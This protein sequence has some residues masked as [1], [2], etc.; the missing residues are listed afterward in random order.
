V[1]RRRSS[2]S[3]IVALA[4]AGAVLVVLKTAVPSLRL[5]G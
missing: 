4:V 3:V 5:G 2:S 1:S